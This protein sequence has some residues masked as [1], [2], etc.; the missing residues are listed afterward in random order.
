MKVAVI[1]TGGREH[2]LAVKSLR[3]PLVDEV[4]VIPGNTGMLIT[5]R[6]K[7]Y[8]DG[9]GSFPTLESYLKQQGITLVIVGNEAFLEAG[10][11]DYFAHSP[12]TVFGPSKAAAKLEY[13]KDFAKQFMHR[14]NIPTA[15]F[16]TCH[17]YD[18]EFSC[19]QVR[20]GTV[21]IKQDG[22][23]LGKGVLVTKDREEANNF[24]QESFAVTD[25]V[26]FED[27]L[28]GKE[29]SLLAF[30]HER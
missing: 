15:D 21:V 3:S 20:S 27:F 26:V 5:Q 19:L 23:A 18:E 9:D 17:S 2:A 28:E 14:H 6:L 16:V 8:S 24:L 25:T 30:V 7:T 12:I 4:H 1:G 13:S 11:A 10:I 29:F 22:L